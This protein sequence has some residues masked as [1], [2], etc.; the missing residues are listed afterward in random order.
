MSVQAVDYAKLKT[1]L[2]KDGQVLDKERRAKSTAADAI[3]PKS[4]KGI[5]A[6]DESAKKTGDWSDSTATKGYIGHSYL[7]DGNEG[8]GTKSVTFS[9]PV[10]KGGEYTLEVAYTAL[11]NRA[12]NV[13]VSITTAA[14][15]QKATL[16]QQAAPRNGAFH[17]VGK[18]NFKTGETATVT[19]SNENTNGHVIVDAVRLLGD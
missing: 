10:T 9:L 5:V 19:I 17:P 1:R 12:S 7:H 6:D 3:D 18:Y 8:K 13:P 15:L 4:L 11:A 16:N 14:G 2:E